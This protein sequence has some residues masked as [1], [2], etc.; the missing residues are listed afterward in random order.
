MMTRTSR[1]QLPVSIAPLAEQHLA[2]VDALRQQLLGEPSNLKFVQ[3]GLAA[4]NQDH[5][6]ALAAASQ[7]VVGYAAAMHAGGESQLLAVAV[8]PG[9]QGQ[10]I[11]TQL[12]AQLLAAA[13]AQGMEAFV[14]EVRATNRRAQELYRRFGFAPVAVRKDYY[15]PSAVGPRED[16]LVMWLADL[17]SPQVQGQ[18]ASLKA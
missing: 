15:P 17:A 18:L 16:A 11:A 12:L 3:A 9:W 13:A 4:A 8:L 2:E 10:G 7:A 6:V 5:L 14:L 1:V